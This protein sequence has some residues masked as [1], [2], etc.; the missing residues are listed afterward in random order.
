MATE[1]KPAKHTIVRTMLI[2][3][4]T[5]EM[6]ASTPYLLGYETTQSSIQPSARCLRHLS[7]ISLLPYS[8]THR[9][10][11]FLGCCFMTMEHIEWRPCQDSLLYRMRSW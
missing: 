8:G 4:T 5:A 1:F 9:R 10:A 3:M 7:T 6:T 2:L 11:V